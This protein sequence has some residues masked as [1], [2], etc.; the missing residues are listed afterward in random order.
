MTSPVQPDLFGAVHVEA[1]DLTRG[2]TVRRGGAAFTV[3]DVEHHRDSAV[4]RGKD[5]RHGGLVEIGCWPATP[6]EV[7]T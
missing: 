4:V 3:T 2:T 5:L 7:I 6:F 1:K